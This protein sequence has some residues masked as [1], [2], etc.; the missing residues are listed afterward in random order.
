MRAEP[1][2]TKGGTCS[3]LS[4]NIAGGLSINSL[5]VT[6]VDNGGASGTTHPGSMG[7]VSYRVGTTGSGGSQYSVRHTDGWGN[8]AG[9]INMDAE[10]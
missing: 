9:W 4:I 2:I 6:G 10:L 3:T 7:N 5:A 8:G 1:A